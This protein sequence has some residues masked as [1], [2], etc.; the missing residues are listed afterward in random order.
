LS[1]VRRR[2]APPNIAFRALTKRVVFFTQKQNHAQDDGLM[3]QGVP[4][5]V[6]ANHD[7]M[8]PMIRWMV[9]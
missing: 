7:D 5:S 4:V 2:S 9:K 1:G 8:T 6:G 3:T